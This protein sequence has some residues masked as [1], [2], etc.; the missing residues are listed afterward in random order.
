MNTRLKDRRLELGMTLEDVGNIV[1]V[2]KTTV[3]KW[4]TGDIENMKRDKIVLLANALKTT[5]NFIMGIDEDNDPIFN[6]PNVLPLSKQRIPLLGKIACGVPIY[7]EQNFEEYVE[8]GHDVNADFALRCQGDSMINANI[9][10]GDIVFIRRQPTV[11]NGEIACVLIEDEAT[12][13]RVYITKSQI[14]LVSE[15]SLFAP[16][17]IT[18][19]DMNYVRILGKA[20]K[21]LTDVK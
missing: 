15:N 18:G 14:T 2:T 3:R 1:G 19:E 17:T 5:P 13:K 16:V 6:I 10:D 7:A 8:C 12:L 20:V 11:N 9:C 21:F 4:E